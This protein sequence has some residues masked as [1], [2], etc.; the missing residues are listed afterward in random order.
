MVD[1][2]RTPDGALK[3]SVHQTDLRLNVDVARVSP[4]SRC[5]RSVSILRDSADSVHVSR[6]DFYDYRRP[7]TAPESTQTC[8]A[9]TSR[10]VPQTSGGICSLGTDEADEGP[11][12]TKALKKPA[13]GPD[14]EAEAKVRL[15][16]TPPRAAKN[17]PEAAVKILPSANSSEVHV[18][19]PAS[20]IGGTGIDAT[21][22]QATV[23]EAARTRSGRPTSI[24]L[25]AETAYMEADRLAEKMVARRWSES[26]SGSSRALPPGSPTAD[27]E[28]P[29]VLEQKQACLPPP[30]TPEGPS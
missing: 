27:G 16:I 24:Y 4:G 26:L 14:T 25:G 13:Q 21:P 1:I 7:R 28:R 12:S 6:G 18:V 30:F 9:A 11:G 20:L 10:K 15:G 8:V 29:S 23:T 2:G 5:L 22:A 17:K 19:G 3:D